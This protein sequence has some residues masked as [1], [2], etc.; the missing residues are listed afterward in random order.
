MNKGDGGMNQ[1]LQR[2]GWWVDEDGKHHVQ[3]MWTTKTVTG[4][5]GNTVDVKVAKGLKTV[6]NE[7]GYGPSAGSKNFNKAQYFEYLFQ[8]HD[9]KTAK[10]LLEERFEE[11]GDDFEMIFAPKFQCELQTIEW[12]WCSLKCVL[13]G[14]EESR[15]KI[16]STIEDAKKTVN[17][18]N[19]HLI[20]RFW[21]SMWRW[22]HAYAVNDSAE[23]TEHHDP[24]MM[25][26]L[27]HTTSHRATSYSRAPEAALDHRKENCPCVGCVPTNTCQQPQCGEDACVEART[28]D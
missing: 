9:F 19:I 8:R 14:R 26:K 22:V 27:I 18:M 16:N 20:H 5:D 4:E 17:T 6:C 21:G 24:A 2:P 13:R 28:P 12:C 25:K 23:G 15:M 3:E 7:R 11:H 10:T 1:R